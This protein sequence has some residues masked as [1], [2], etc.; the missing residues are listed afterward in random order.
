MKI[1]KLMLE[2]MKTALAE[3]KIELKVTEAAYKTIASKAYG[4]KYGGRDIRRV[5][6]KELEDKVADLVIEKGEGGISEV[7]VSSKA[8]E[9]VV[10]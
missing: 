4:G 8:G 2:E 6:R 1:A 3:K 10:S 9:L 7:N 5:I